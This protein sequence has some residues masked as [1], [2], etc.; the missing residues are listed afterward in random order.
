MPGI[1]KTFRFRLFLSYL[2]LSA[3]VLGAAFFLVY[4]RIESAALRTWLPVILTHWR[5]PL[6]PK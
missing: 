2:A 3:A 4:Q 5:I 6:V 1:F